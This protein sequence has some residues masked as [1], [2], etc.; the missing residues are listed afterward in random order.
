MGNLDTLSPALHVE[1]KDLLVREAACLDERRWDDWLALYLPDC[2][3]WLMAW[4]S[5]HE[6]ATDPKADV[7]LIYYDS[8]RGLEDRVV[9]IRSG[10]SAASTPLPRTWHWVGN[11]I[12]DA[13]HPGELTVH[14]KWQT[15]SFRNRHT[16]T[17]YG[18][19]EYQLRRTEGAW[20]IASKRI[21]LLND[22]V[23]TV[24][25]VYNV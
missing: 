14:A 15:R 19:Y 18:T 20:R 10:L 16:D 9:R 11:L 25:D 2:R 21:V 1:V 24:L 13:S 6:L 5:E 3:Y 23:Y 22:V 8:R 12:L 17:Y 4:D 7:S